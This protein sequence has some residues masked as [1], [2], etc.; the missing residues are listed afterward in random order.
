MK[1]EHPEDMIA[2]FQRDIIDSAE[3]NVNVAV[4]L[5]HSI[6]LSMLVTK[7]EGNAEKVIE[8]MEEL[9][10]YTW[11]GIDSGELDLRAYQ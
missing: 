7:H 8:E 9:N 4:K 5:A 3:G 1:Y 11:K 2:A 10:R 6:F